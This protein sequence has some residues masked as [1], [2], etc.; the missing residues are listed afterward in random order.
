MFWKEVKRERHG[1]ESVRVK[2]E[3]RILEEVRGVWKSL[4]EH[5]MSVKTEGEAGVECIPFWR[6]SCNDW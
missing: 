5:L 4:F 1:G 3:D 6:Y 2:R